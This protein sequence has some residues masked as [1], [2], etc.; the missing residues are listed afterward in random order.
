MRTEASTLHLGR[1]R[2][3]LSRNQL[4]MTLIEFSLVL[5]IVTLLA[6]LGIPSTQKLF[7]DQRLRGLKD[8]LMVHLNIAR[9]TAVHQSRATVIC[10]SADGFY[11]LEAGHWQAGWI[12]FLDANRDRKR[13]DEEAIVQIAHG[14]GW[15]DIKSGNR[16][17]FRFRFDG[18]ATGSNGSFRICDQ[19]GA[20][21]G[22][23]LII[24]TVGRIRSEGP[25]IARC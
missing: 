22:W 17:R 3:V 15:A 8:E 2:R 5:L 7:H 6:T 24:S 19:R 9:H 25:G 12:V 16:K 13:S 14:R 23:R 21:Y 4:G 11:C 18:T 20:E 10:P 1:K